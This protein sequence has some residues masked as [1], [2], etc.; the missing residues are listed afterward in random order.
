MTKIVAQRVLDH[1]LEDK[2]VASSIATFRG[3]RDSVSVSY[4][5]YLLVDM[6]A[7]L[8]EWLFLKIFDAIAVKA[9]KRPGKYRND[10]TNETKRYLWTLNKAIKYGATYPPNHTV[11]YTSLVTDG[12]GLR[13]D[14]YGDDTYEVKT[15][16]AREVLYNKMYDGFASN[17]VELIEI[18]WGEKKGEVH[19][20]LTNDYEDR[21]TEKIANYV[22]KEL[23]STTNPTKTQLLCYLSA[24][25]IICENKQEYAGIL[26]LFLHFSETNEDVVQR[27]TDALSNLG[28]FELQKCKSIHA[29]SLDDR[30]AAIQWLGESKRDD[31]LDPL[32]LCLG[33]EKTQDQAIAVLRSLHVEETDIEQHLEIAILRNKLQQIEKEFSKE[34]LSDICQYTDSVFIQPILDTIRRLVLFYSELRF[35]DFTKQKIIST[36]LR[37]AFSLDWDKTYA[38]ISELADRCEK[39][40]AFIELCIN[41]I[42]ELNDKRFVSFL[43]QHLF[44]G[45]HAS[46]RN[47]YR[48]ES[49]F[50]LAKI[51]GEETVDALTEFVRKMALSSI[52]LEDKEKEGIDQVIKVLIQH[53][54][55]PG[56]PTALFKFAD[57]ERFDESMDRSLISDIFS[58]VGESKEGEQLLSDLKDIAEPGYCCF[59]FW[60]PPTPRYNYQFRAIEAQKTIK[61]IRNSR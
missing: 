26:Y 3:D 34:L 49:V 56:V 61:A 29:I 19:P 31:A 21:N 37:H 54:N 40:D 13:W 27:A 46:L 48:L 18:L 23:T 6:G 58:L 38:V 8:P 2:Q 43:K 22:Q 47:G 44:G 15:I 50:A 36:L 42:C 28:E 30:L 4:F 53:P 9:I 12:N 52:F 45:I 59:C 1:A 39:H 33:E 24:M 35:N 41:L 17:E 25:E 16:A 32:F 55:H 60:C 14:R 11:S 51:G 5:L 7:K 10:M 57:S 20:S